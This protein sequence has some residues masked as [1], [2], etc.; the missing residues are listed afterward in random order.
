MAKLT[1]IVVSAFLFFQTIIYSSETEA[2][3]EFCFVICSY[4]NVSCCEENLESVFCQTYPHWSIYYTDD[5]STDGTGEKVD[6]YVKRKGMSERCHVV[7]NSVRQGA[8]KNSYR[9]I[10]SCSPRTVIV[11]LDGDDTL[12]DPSVLETLARVYSD[13]SVWITYGSD[14][15]LSSGKRAPRCH[16]FP[17]EVM[18]NRTFRKYRWIANLPRTF[19]AGLFHKIHK[20]DLMYEG[21]FVPICCDVAYMFPMFE[22]ASQGHIR[23]IEKILYVYNDSNPLNDIRTRRELNRKMSKYLASKKP[24]PPLKKLF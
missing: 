6:A 15:H 16:A 14:R 20:K 10:Y 23:Y 1:K 5:C 13:P 3:I 21:E 8:M 12:S 9:A 4:N 18:K 11:I 17:Q 2:P 19:Y 7:H 24:Y 22:M